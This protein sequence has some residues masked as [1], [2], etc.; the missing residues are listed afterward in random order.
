M[1]DN[2]PL[3]RRILVT[4]DASV[5]GRLALSLI[6]ELAA[7]TPVEV[8]GVFIEDLN[9]LH[10]AE[11]PFAWEVIV[12]SAASRRLEQ[13]RLE[14]SLREQAAQVQRIFADYAGR[15]GL[16][17]SFRVVRGHFPK[18]L[19]S[20][21][22]GF[23]LCIIGQ[24]G[25]LALQRLTRKQ[26]AP[27]RTVVALVTDTPSAMRILQVATRLARAQGRHLLVLSADGQVSSPV[28]RR[29]RAE[30][31]QAE[32]IDWPLSEAGNLRRILMR[33]EPMALVMDATLLTGAGLQPL[34]GD[35]DFP[36]LLVRQALS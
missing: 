9:L 36:V 30:L 27:G 35:L 24:G 15:V 23:D 21:A 33:R 2:E 18:E 19:L 7:E 26:P 25:S 32:W 14:R 34:L 20:L 8:Q 31:N 10:L 13:V 12:T 11:L 29:L 3:I 4:A 6:G 28:L 22:E 1:T 17:W 16:T 5:R